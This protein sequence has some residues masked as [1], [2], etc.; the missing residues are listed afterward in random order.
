MC[1]PPVFNGLGNPVVAENWI[2][3]ME[4]IFNFLHCNDQ[5]R[6]T[7]MTFQLTGS[8]D[9]WW[10]ARKKILTP[11]QLAQMTWNEFKTGMYDK[12]IPKSYRKAKEVEF[13]NLKQGRMSVT[14]YDIMFCD[15]S[16]YAPD[17]VDTDEK[18]AD[19]F[20]AGLRYEIRMALAS[21][22]GLSYPES[23][24]RALDIEAAMPREKSTIL[25]AAAPPQQQQNFR[26]KRRWDNSLWETLS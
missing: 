8:A 23:L 3:A 15:M 17:Q 20:C 7:C 5:E 11:E 13:Y 6:L 18:M 10:E 2:R 9:F 22:G 21:L 19:K 12:Y 1:N 4:R 14:E 24:S 16:R 26:E 25:V